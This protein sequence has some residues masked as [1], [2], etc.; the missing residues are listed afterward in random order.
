MQLPRGWDWREELVAVP[1]PCL[2]HQHPSWSLLNP[3]GRWGPCSTDG[4]TEA[5]R[6]LWT[7]QGDTDGG[8]WRQDQNPGPPADGRSL[9][10]GVHGVCVFQ[11]QAMREQS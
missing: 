7:S 3:R 2:C 6:V 10:R 9:R 4:E 11:I 5:Q 8:E 1:T